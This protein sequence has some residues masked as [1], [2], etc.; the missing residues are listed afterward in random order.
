MT[1][2]N[3]PKLLITQGSIPHWQFEDSFYFLTWRLHKDQVDLNEHERELV[4]SV[5]RFFDDKR[6]VLFSYVIMNDHVHVLVKLFSKESLPKIIHS[7]KSYVANRLQRQFKRKGRIWQQEYFDTI[8]RNDEQFYSTVK[9]ILNN[10]WKRWGV[11]EYKWR[12]Y[13]ENPFGE[14]QA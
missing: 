11:E 4:A 10:P 1:P 5:L 13:K 8:I 12:W 14:G 3:D 9:Y 2:D 7:W 6:Y